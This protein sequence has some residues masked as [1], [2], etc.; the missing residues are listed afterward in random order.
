M[1]YSENA[2]VDFLKIPIQTHH[3]QDKRY[4]VTM[5]IAIYILALIWLELPMPVTNIKGNICLLE[6]TNSCILCVIVGGGDSHALGKYRFMD[7]KGVLGNV[8]WMVG[9]NVVQIPYIVHVPYVGCTIFCL[10]I[11]NKVPVL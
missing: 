6:W 1:W 8:F 10:Q 5:W 2:D 9:I 11:P 4:H 7:K 3:Q